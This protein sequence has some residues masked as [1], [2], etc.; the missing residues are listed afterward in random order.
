MT[1]QK[2]LPNPLR[3]L[4]PRTLFSALSLAFVAATAFTPT[5]DANASS[6][7]WY[8]AG[9]RSSMLNQYV[10]QRNCFGGE[11]V[12]NGCISAINSILAQAKPVVRIVPASDTTVPPVSERLPSGVGYIRLTG[13]ETIVGSTDAAYWRNFVANRNTNYRKWTRLYANK[14][15]SS[16][17]GY[18]PNH[19]DLVDFTKLVNWAFHRLRTYDASIE[20]SA[21]ADAINEY[22]GAAID[23]HAKI[24]LKSDDAAMT[25]SVTLGA[26]PAKTTAE[27][28]EENQELASAELGLEV[29]YD[30]AGQLTVY[31]P[32]PGGSAYRAGIKYRDVILEIDDVPVGDLTNAELNRKLDSDEPGV[33]RRLKIRRKDAKGATQDYIATLPYEEIAAERASFQNGIGIL[34][35][36]E[37]NE[38]TGLRLRAKAEELARA[39]TIR[40]WILDLRGNGGGL[41]SEAVDVANIFL[42]EGTEVAQLKYTD[43]KSV[44]GLSSVSLAPGQTRFDLEIGPQIHS[45]IQFA[46]DQKTVV[47]AVESH[48]TAMERFTNLPLV[49]MID[50]LSASASEIVAGA[51]QT[52]K[53]AFLIGDRSFGKGSIQTIEPWKSLPASVNYRHT[54]GRFYQP[55]GLRTNQWVGIL[56]EIEVHRT[57]NATADESFFAREEDYY[58]HSLSAEN[59]PYVTDRPVAARKFKECTAAR[60]PA[61]KKR[62]AAEMKAIGSTLPPDYQMLSARAAVECAIYLVGRD[63]K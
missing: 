3:N 19:R 49:V 36:R 14:L 15:D 8:N 59:S 13:P 57:P 34:S 35:L 29:K 43:F 28:P 56:P 55:G 62:Y 40:A 51:L 53:R 12:F 16:R 26:A 44:T 50:G 41:V 27:N 2:S 23:A 11:L 17:P 7:P 42:P 33:V 9:L 24:S 52:H 48:R 4:F 25:A 5:N 60:L 31:R 37:F 47:S 45:T 38:G 20:S 30:S 54:V 1:T 58:F 46:D 61:A 10:N 32:T 18:T 22:F 39:H 63:Q 21:T 6:D